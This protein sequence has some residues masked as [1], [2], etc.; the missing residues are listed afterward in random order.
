MSDTE[1]TSFESSGGPGVEELRSEVQSLRTILSCSLLL[2]FVFSFCV[3]IFLFR[4]TSMVSGQLAQVNQL[5]SAW[6]SG[7]PAQAQ[8]IDF[9]GKLNEFAKTHPDFT[10]I[11]NKY[12]SYINVHPTVQPKK[13]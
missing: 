10:P 2:L 13:K 3:N 11:I 4:Q 5:L 1:K 9:W 12:S 6:A 7:G 8:A